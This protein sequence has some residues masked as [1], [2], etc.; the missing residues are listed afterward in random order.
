LV[1]PAGKSVQEDF[2]T[3]ALERTE[4]I[5]YL[6]GPIDYSLANPSDSFDEMIACIT[7]ALGEDTLLF[8]PLKAFCNAN[9]AKERHECDYIFNVN[10]RALRAADLAV[11]RVDDS[12]SFGVP[13]EIYEC[14]RQRIP[15]IVWYQR[16][17]SPGVY[18]QYLCN[19]LVKTKTD[20]IQALR[21]F[22]KEKE[23]ENVKEVHL[24]PQKQEE[25][26]EPVMT[27]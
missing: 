2:N 21:A 6:A 16:Q 12:P 8:N 22:K 4:M 23:L 18:V 3:E 13:I 11:F 27:C 26:L 24:A 1:P 15:A 5:V 10:M 9:K 17:A 14:T 19:T 20:L 25:S 7:S